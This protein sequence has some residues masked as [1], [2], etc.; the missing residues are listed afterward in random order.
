M[1]G[2]FRKGYVLVQTEIRLKCRAVGKEII[3][4]K[5]ELMSIVFWLISGNDSSANHE[6]RERVRDQGEP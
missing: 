1:E 2:L 5:I 3:L 6:D 4:T